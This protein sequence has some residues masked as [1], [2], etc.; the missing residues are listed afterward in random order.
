RMSEVKKLASYA[1][2]TWVEAN[3]KAATLYHAVTGEPVAA[4]SS[5]GLDFKAMLDYGRRLGGPALRRLTF[6]Q[7]ARMLKALATFLMERKDRFYGISAATGATKTDSWVDIEGGIGTLFAYASRGRREFPDETFYIDG[8]PE[9]LSKGGTFVGRHICVPL[10]GV[11]VHINA[12]NFPVWG[13]L[14]KLSPTLLAGVPAIVK[15]ATL[16][17]YLTEAV[18]RAMIESRILPDGTIQ[19]VCGSA[20]DL[21]DHLDAQCAVAFTGSAQTARALRAKRAILDNNVRFNTEAD[22]LNF[23]MLGPDAAPGSEEFDLFVK[24]VAK[25][26][27]VKAG[28]KCT[29][30][31]RTLVPA[32]LVEDVAKALGRRL[33]GVKAGNPSREG[34][35]MGPLA[36]RGQ[37]RE[38]EP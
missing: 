4:A 27:T 21:L 1:Q 26:M 32:A 12:F 18:F 14:E 38:G 37:R 20:G 17:S 10:E 28:Q 8:G 3:G 31:R 24:E 22:S 2:G 13:M 36:G 16:T 30:I 5:E 35:R 25:E 19:L 6:H 29:A 9:P 15:P 33:A 23:S 7:R 34:V 11:A